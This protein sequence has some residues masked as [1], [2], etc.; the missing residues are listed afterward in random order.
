MPS[1][2]SLEERLEALASSLPDSEKESFSQIKD[3]VYNLIKDQKD[4][5]FQLNKSEKKNRVLQQNMEQE[6]KAKSDLMS[7]CAHDLKSPTGNIMSYLEILKADWSVLKASDINNILA[8]M[9][10]TTEHMLELIDDLLV[11]GSNE[12]GELT[13]SPEPVYVSHLCQDIVESQ[14]A[15]MANKEIELEL[16]I[17]KGEL[18]V[19]LD[20]SKGMQIIN[21]LISNAMKFTPRGGKIELIVTHKEKR[22]YLEIKDNGQGIKEEELE[23]I[24]EKFQKT[25]TK[26][27]EGE[28][29]TGLGLAIVKQLVDMHKGNIHVKSKYGEGT[30]FI[31]DLPVAEDSKLLKLFSGKK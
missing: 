27:T 13:I 6:H 19:K 4:L 8:R 5:I 26:S 21:N 24:F 22:I 18:R 20:I 3:E 9:S 31:I 14:K 15:T 23:K 1:S 7:T 17:N 25:S 28:K 12:T 30:S 16:I 2:D 11:T 29:S 10:R